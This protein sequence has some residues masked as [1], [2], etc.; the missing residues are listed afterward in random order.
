MGLSKSEFL[1]NYLHNVA[2][3]KATYTIIL[4]ILFCLTSIYFFGTLIFKN[5]TIATSF[6]INKM[7]LNDQLD[8]DEKV[9]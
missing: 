5:E 1:F 3:G 2:V 4:C 9:L 6:A 8:A 7:R